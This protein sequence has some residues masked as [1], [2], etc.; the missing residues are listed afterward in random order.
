M[1]YREDEQCSKEGKALYLDG[2]ERLIKKRESEARERRREYVRD[3]FSRPDSYR[4]D[5]CR[6]LGWPLVG[7]AR[8]GAP[9]VSKT[10]LSEEA[11][12][13]IYRMQIE[14]LDTLT[15]SGLYFEMTGE[16]K[17]PLVLVQHGGRG[18][19]EAISGVYGTTTNY[20]GM[21]ERVIAYGTHAFAPQLLLWDKKY[22]VE[23]DRQNIDARL[24]RVGGSVT[25][26]EVYSL[27]RTLD[28]FETLENVCCFGMVGLS[29]GGFYTLMLSAI[30]ER[31]RSAISCAFFNTRDSYPWNDWCWFGAAEH[32][33]DA[34]IAAL[35][36][37]RRLCIELGRDDPLFSFPGGESSYERL[38]EM[39]RDVGTDWLDFIPFDGN[40]EFC[41][42]D[43]PI[44]RLV[45]DLGM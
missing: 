36:Y 17:R 13:N 44:A 6:M 29:Y 43:E 1:I 2:I 22:D 41:K 15:L 21:L 28:Y 3:I 9:R 31:I 42:F 25:A 11:G 39:S 8:E 35:V 16:G 38:L 12:Y 37:P 10:L 14:V 40:H 18:T 5:L 20:N 30:D 34:E 27:E 24:K 7:E 26:L 23:F 19:P 33:D 32:F 4:R 45:K